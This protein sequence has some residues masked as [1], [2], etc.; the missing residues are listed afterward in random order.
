[1]PGRRRRH[2]LLGPAH[3]SALRRAA[4]LY[5]PEVVNRT[6][7]GGERPQEP[8][9]TR[10]LGAIRGL[11]VFRVLRHRPPCQNRPWARLGSNHVLGASRPNRSCTSWRPSSGW[12]RTSGARTSRNGGLGDRGGRGGRQIGTAEAVGWLA[13]R[14]AWSGPDRGG[15]PR[16]S[17]GPRRAGNGL[18]PLMLE[19]RIEIRWRDVD[20]Y[21][22]VNNAV[23]LNY[24]EEARDAGA[25]GPRAGVRH[26][27][28]L[29]PCPR[30]DRLSHRADAGRPR[31]DRPVHARPDRAIEHRD[32]RGGSQ[33]GRDDLGGGTIG[34]GGQRPGDGALAAPHRART[35]VPEAERTA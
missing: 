33:G 8:P 21:G 34:G 26:H 10:G 25:V 3:R 13:E 14:E 7:G 18:G 19:K 31:G 24:L 23:Y 12:S 35:R 1:M 16:G 27:L 32:A 4:S 5:L 22:H 6:A 15:I 2:G 28:G 9:L 20:A 29:R 30:G 11:R 17:S